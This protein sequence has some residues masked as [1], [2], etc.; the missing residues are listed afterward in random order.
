MTG[1]AIGID[2]HEP[3][4]IGGSC[5][6]LEAGYAL[7]IEPG[8]YALDVAGVRVEDLVIVTKDGLENPN[9]FGTELVV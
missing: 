6:E 7:T 4:R 1:H 2:G 5:G 3:P 9:D 8:L